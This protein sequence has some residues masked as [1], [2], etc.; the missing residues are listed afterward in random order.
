MVLLADGIAT[1]FQFQWDIL[2]TA[3]I[4]YRLHTL[5]LREEF[6]EVTGQ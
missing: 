6:T 5:G 3:N 4:F 2:C 1:F